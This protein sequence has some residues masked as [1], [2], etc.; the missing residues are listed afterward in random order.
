MA[1]DQLRVGGLLFKRDHYVRVVDFRNDTEIEH[2]F[3][4]MQTE[5]HRFI[6]RRVK[7]VRIDSQDPLWNFAL[8]DSMWLWPGRWL[9]PVDNGLR[10]L[11]RRYRHARV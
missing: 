10:D 5:R 9:V 6:G 1:V 8:E 3:R 7:I 11:V 2:Y 4:A